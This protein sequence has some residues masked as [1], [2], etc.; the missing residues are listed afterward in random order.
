MPTGTPDKYQYS[1]KMIG[2]MTAGFGAFSFILMGL[3]TD[4]VFASK[5]TAVVILGVIAFG[6]YMRRASPPP[7]SN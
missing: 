6:A 1:W 4:W 7:K 5:M 2:A 3:S